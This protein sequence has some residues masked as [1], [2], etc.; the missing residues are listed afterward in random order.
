MKQSTNQVLAGALQDDCR[1]VLRG[2]RTFGKGLVQAV[3]GLADGQGLILTVAQYETPRGTYIHVR[4]VFAFSAAFVTVTRLAAASA[5]TKA[6]PEFV[7]RRTIERL[8][9][10]GRLRG[11]GSISSCGWRLSERWPTRRLFPSTCLPGSRIS[12][13]MTKVHER[14]YSSPLSLTACGVLGE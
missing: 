5:V 8:R 2:E 10:A 12:R 3:Y 14:V 7:F 9:G 6:V 4:P 13:A 11:P 1:A